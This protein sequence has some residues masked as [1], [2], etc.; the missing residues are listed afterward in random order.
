MA[1]LLPIPLMTLIANATLCFPLTLVFCTLK[2]GV[3]SLAF[4]NTSELYNT[5]Q[6]V[7]GF[8][9]TEC[10]IYKPRKE[11]SFRSPINA[12]TIVREHDIGE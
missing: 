4:C 1:N 12:H 7:N 8:E 10:L 3:K 2:S 5:R 6:H 11:S 9:Q